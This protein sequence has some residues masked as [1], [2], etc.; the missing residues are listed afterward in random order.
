M[1]EAARRVAESEG[2]LPDILAAAAARAQIA[3]V[4]ERPDTS[5]DQG[6]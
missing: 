5:R 4:R 6:R 2:T 1:N 3:P